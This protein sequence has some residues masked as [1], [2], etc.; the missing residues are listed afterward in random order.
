MNQKAIL[1]FDFRSLIA[2]ILFALLILPSTILVGSHP[3]L[4]RSGDQMLVRVFLADP[5][6]IRQ[7]REMGIEVVSD[8]EGR[9]RIDVM[10]SQP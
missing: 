10:A 9:T 1:N 7:V 8:I 4:G 2:L 5:I 6:Q 3:A